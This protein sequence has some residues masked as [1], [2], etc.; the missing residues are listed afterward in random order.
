MRRGRYRGVQNTP[1]DCTAQRHLTRRQRTA[2]VLLIGNYPLDRQQSM[3]RFSTMMLEGLTAAGVAAELIQPRAMMGRFRLA[4]NL[5]AK[6]PAY[7]ENI[8][9]IPRHL[10]AR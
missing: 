10:H 6:W 9:R 5:V 8:V 1:A 2:M 7:V 4:G 3:L